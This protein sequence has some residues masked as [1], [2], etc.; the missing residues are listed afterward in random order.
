[1][2][3]DLFEK[4]SKKRNNHIVCGDL[5]A[6]IRQNQ[7]GGIL[8][9]ILLSSNMLVLNTKDNTYVGFGDQKESVLDYCICS[10][11]LHTKMDKFEVLKNEDM[12]SDHLPFKVD[13]NFSTNCVQHPQV[14]DMNEDDMPNW[15]KADWPKYAE[16]LPSNIPND[17]DYDIEGL[18]KFIT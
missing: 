4:I 15:K 3:K 18:N 12:N 13:L 9:E 8:E 16:Y 1:L 2:S 17:L 7:N 6:K 14:A 10:P 11:E 5:N